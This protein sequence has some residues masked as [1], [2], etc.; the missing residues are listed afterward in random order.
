MVTSCGNRTPQ[1]SNRAPTSSRLSV[2]STEI[3]QPDTT[4]SPTTASI[5]TLTT[6]PASTVA[7]S[8]TTTITT[9]TTTIPTTTTTTITT[10]T[11][12]TAPCLPPGEVLTTASGRRVLLRAAGG[13]SAAPTIIV[14]HGFT[15]T[16]TGI[17]RVSDMTSAANTAGITV[18]YLEGTP[19][20]P[21]GFGWTTG[22]LV[23]ASTGV[24]D[25]AALVDMIDALVATGCTDRAQITITGE[26]N[27]AGMTLNALCDPR[28]DGA[29]RSAVMVI[30]AID[31]GVL[32]RCSKTVDQLIPII[33]VAGQ[34]DRTAPIDGGNGL[35][36]QSIWFEQ[37]AAER[38]CRG[39]E[40]PV[41]LT[42]FA[43]LRSGQGCGPCTELIVVADGPHTW[44]GTP[45]G[46]AGLTPGTFDLNRRIIAD[47]LAPEPGCLSTR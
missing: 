5:E 6:T 47:V 35:L 25:V 40:S 2:V 19:V 31:D 4:S 44:P 39:V 42:Q 37:V 30:P 45:A 12:P 15:G 10:P 11:A 16:P 26:S 43:Q 13:V 28:L 38:G 27:G 36:P 23:S 8:R 32:A 46:T 20:R 21:S 1:T 29:F 17:E 18:A 9:T 33:A 34:I 22:A 7:E 41:P 24:D 14:I 3:V